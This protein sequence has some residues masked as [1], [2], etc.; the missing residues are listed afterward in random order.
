MKALLLG[1]SFVP[2]SFNTRINPCAWPFCWIPHRPKTNELIQDSPH[3]LI[4]PKKKLGIPN[5]AHKSTF[6]WIQWIPMENRGWSSHTFRISQ[7]PN[8]SVPK[9]KEYR[10]TV[11]PIHI[12]PL[13]GYAELLKIQDPKIRWFPSL[14]QPFP[15]E[16]RPEF[17]NLQHRF[18]RWYEMIWNM[19]SPFCFRKAFFLQPKGTPHGRG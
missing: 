14:S 13:Q 11:I 12:T 15:N 5:L 4:R 17:P 7:E 18:Q 10:N 3:M 6:H 1:H 2:P 8:L 9:V 16:L 19:M